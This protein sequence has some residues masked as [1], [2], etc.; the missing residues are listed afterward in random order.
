M[1][2]PLDFSIH[3]A[4]AAAIRDGMLAFSEANDDASYNGAQYWLY[5]WI[6]DTNKVTA[7]ERNDINGLPANYVLDQNYPNP[8]NPN[9]TIEYHLPKSALVNISIYNVLGQQVT[10]LVNSRQPAGEQKIVFDG[11]KL[12]S[13]VY[14]Y[15]LQTDDF[16]QVKKMLLMK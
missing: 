16:V 3:D 10:T 1:R 11:S 13:G 12:S 6:G 14:F 15:K 7:I 2:I 5:M 4:D 8:F 9:T